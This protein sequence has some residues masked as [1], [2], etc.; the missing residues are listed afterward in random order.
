MVLTQGTGVIADRIQW[1]LVG[2]LTRYGVG[3]ILGVQEK[4]KKKKKNCWNLVY[5][6]EILL[7][8]SSI[9]CFRNKRI[10]LD[11]RKMWQLFRVS[12]NLKNC[13]ILSWRRPGNIWKHGLELRKENWSTNRIANIS[14]KM[15]F[16]DAIRVAGTSSRG[17]GS[18]QRRAGAECLCNTESNKRGA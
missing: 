15:L 3:Y 17:I 2:S 5:N 14:S 12:L 13:E 6:L 1:L 18:S 8:C 16:T 9:N 11:S 4:A 7:Q 10:A